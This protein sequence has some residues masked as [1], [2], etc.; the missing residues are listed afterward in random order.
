MTHYE[1]FDCNLDKGNSPAR[2]VGR[3]FEKLGSGHYLEMTSTNITLLLTFESTLI[4]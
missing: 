2:N 4:S 1:V 3:N